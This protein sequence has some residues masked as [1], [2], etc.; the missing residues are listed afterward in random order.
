SSSL[1]IVQNLLLQSGALH[2]RNYHCSYLSHGTIK[3]SHHD[4]FSGRVKRCSGRFIGN[5]LNLRSLVSVLLVGIRAYECLICFYRSTLRSK[6][7][8]RSSLEGK[9]QTLQNEPSRLLSNS[10]RL[11]SLVGRD[12]ILAVDEHPERTKP[13]VQSDRRILKDRPKLYRKLL[14][15]LFAFPS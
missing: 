2:I 15:A 8:N 1:D 14:V 5:R 7:L 3:H 11:G 12:S 13:L 6:L 9:S 4:S 10:N